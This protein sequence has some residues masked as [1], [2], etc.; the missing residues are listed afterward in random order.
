MSN[1]TKTNLMEIENATAA[2]GGLCRGRGL[3]P[4]EA[5]RPEGGDGEMVPDFWTG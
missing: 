1:F 5:R 3:G 4:D 2:G